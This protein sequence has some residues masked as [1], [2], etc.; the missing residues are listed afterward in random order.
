MSEIILE[1]SAAQ[2]AVVLLLWLAGAAFAFVLP[3]AAGFL[4]K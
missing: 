3:I 2:K 4:A 1:R